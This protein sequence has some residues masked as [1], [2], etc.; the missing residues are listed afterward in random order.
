MLACNLMRNLLGL[1]ALVIDPKLCDAGRDHSKDMETLKFFAPRV[2]GRGEEDAVGPGEAV[3]HDGLGGKHRMGYHDGKAANE[4]WF[5]S[6]GHHKTCSRPITSASAS[7]GAGCITRRSLGSDRP[8]GGATLGGCHA[9]ACVG[10]RL[11]PPAN[12]FHRL[13]SMG[14]LRF[15]FAKAQIVG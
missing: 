3:R 10:M 12:H 5:H 4:G 11:V 8:R 15:G 7:G 6:P 1:S 14:P 13:S 2:A 9:H